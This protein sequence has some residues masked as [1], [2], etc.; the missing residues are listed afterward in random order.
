MLELKREAQ[1]NING[2]CIVSGVLWVDHIVYIVAC[3]I[4]THV[5]L[6]SSAVLFA[7]ADG[8]PDHILIPSWRLL[9]HPMDG[10]MSHMH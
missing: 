9:K 1:A 6:A 8:L 5:A 4:S 2:A 7:S 3:S 10:D